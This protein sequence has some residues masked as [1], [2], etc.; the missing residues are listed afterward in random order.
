M[1]DIFPNA[2]SIIAKIVNVQG[3]NCISASEVD[4]YSSL[5]RRFPDM[6]DCLHLSDNILWNCQYKYKEPFH[7]FL[8]PPVSDCL[9]CH[10]TLYTFNVTNVTVFTLEGP[11]PARKLTLR[12][13]KGCGATYSI[14]TY[15]SS[16]TTKFY[17]FPT[18]WIS[19][20][21]KV[22]ISDTVHELMC[23]SG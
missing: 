19:A 6:T 13:K 23:E 11:L 20:S 1:P 2:S 15:N 22:F 14:D 9:Q 4:Q 3:N 17:D 18:Q 12:C 21:N 5:I 16:S 8:V 10:G 7:K